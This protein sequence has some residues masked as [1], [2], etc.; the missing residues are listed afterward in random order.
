MARA[1]YD[2]EHQNEK[3]C[4]NQEN[5]VVSDKQKQV[6]LPRGRALTQYLSGHDEESS[7]SEVH[8]NLEEA[9]EMTRSSGELLTHSI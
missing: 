2:L 3:E 8:D 7:N 4:K 6:S 9:E 5:R 1:R